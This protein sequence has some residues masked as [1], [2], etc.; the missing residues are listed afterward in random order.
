INPNWQQR[1]NELS[2]IEVEIR[3]QT[4]KA[5]RHQRE[6]AKFDSQMDR[7]PEIQQEYARLTRDLDQSKQAYNRLLDTRARAKISDDAAE[8]GPAQFDILEPP[9]ADMTPV[10][11]V[12]PL[13]ILGGLFAALGLGLGLAML[14]QVLAPT[15]TDVSTLERQF[16]LPV[17]GTVS[18][19]R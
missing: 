16:N 10:W 6:L 8:T 5:S 18:A 3:A 15:I 4:S 9:R 7:T 14:P 12:R 1:Q 2:Q 11:P 19:L 17:L 13:F